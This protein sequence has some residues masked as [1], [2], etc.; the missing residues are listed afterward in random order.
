M[1]IVLYQLGVFGSTELKFSP[2]HMKC[3]N[4]NYEY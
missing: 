2:C 3:L 4:N 1:G